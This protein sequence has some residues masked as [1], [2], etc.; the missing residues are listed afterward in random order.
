GS[1]SRHQEQFQAHTE[2]SNREQEGP[3][4]NEKVSAANRCHASIRT[5]SRRVLRAGGLLRICESKLSDD[6]IP[7]VV[8]CRIYLHGAHVDRA[9]DAASMV[10]RLIAPAC[11][12]LALTTLLAIEKEPFGEY[13]ARRDRLVARIM[14]NVLVL[15]PPSGTEF[16]HDQQ[17]CIS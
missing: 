4:G 6:S 17:V 1:A 13:K 3:V 9:H 10:K 11:L 8:C 7:D 14:G 15:G 16:V 12:F 2:I 5:Q